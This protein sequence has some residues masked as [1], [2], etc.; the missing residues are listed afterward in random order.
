MIHSSGRAI[1]T[2]IPPRDRSL[3]SPLIVDGKVQSIDQYVRLASLSG[4][5]G[6]FQKLGFTGLPLA[7]VALT[8]FFALLALNATTGTDMQRVFLDLTKLTLGAFIGSFVQ[9]GQDAPRLPEF[10]KEFLAELN[11]LRA[12][13]TPR[14]DTTQGR[15]D[16]GEAKTAGKPSEQD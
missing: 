3:L 7:T 8:L 12:A 13:K 4:F 5:T 14:S 2:I 1:P 6:T 11:Q 15:S 10:G 16:T 9:R